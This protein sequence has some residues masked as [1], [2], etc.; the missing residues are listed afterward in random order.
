VTR[1][2][3]SGQEPSTPAGAALACFIVAI[4]LAVIGFGGWAWDSMSRPVAIAIV[5]CIV[6]LIVAAMM[7]VYAW[8]QPAKYRVTY[9]LHV[10]S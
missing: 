5:L 10:R 8:V 7:A 6:H 9:R 4:V 1:C 2:E 3:S